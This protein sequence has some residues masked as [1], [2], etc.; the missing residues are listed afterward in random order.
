MKRPQWAAQTTRLLRKQ[1]PR[2]QIFRG[3]IRRLHT[4]RFLVFWVVALQ[5]G[6]HKRKVVG[7][8]SRDADFANR[9]GWN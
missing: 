1:I 7:G 2:T 4:R 8:A 6:T 5:E 3:V 9:N